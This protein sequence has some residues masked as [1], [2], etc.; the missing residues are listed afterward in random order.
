MNIIYDI[1]YLFHH[2]TVVAMWIIPSKIV[3]QSPYTSFKLNSW[4]IYLLFTSLPSFLGFIFIS[5]YPETPRYLMLKGHMTE[6]RQVL[7]RIYSFNHKKS[8]VNYPVSILH[9]LYKSYLY[10]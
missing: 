1:S 9:N 3:L 6:S 8:A 5:R 2:V 7:E 10:F 4:R